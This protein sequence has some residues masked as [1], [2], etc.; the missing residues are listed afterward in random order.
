MRWPSNLLLR[1]RS[2]V[3]K[4]GL[5]RELDDEIRFHIE[6]QI[7]ENVA[8][9]MTPEAARRA[10]L[11]DFGGVDPIKEECRDMRRV[12]LAHDLVKDLRFG[13][14]MIRKNPGFT[15]VAVSILAL[16]I[17]ANTAI[18]SFIDAVMLRA[19]PV[20]DPGELVVLDWRAHTEPK[21]YMI[22][23]HGDCNGIE[24]SAMNH[25]PAGGPSSAGCSFSLPFFD[26]LRARTDLHAGIT[27]FSSAPPLLVSGLGAPAVA[28]GQLVSGAYFATLGVRAALGRTIE[29]DD[30]ARAVPVAVL[31]HAYWQRAFG[32]DPAVVGRTI[33]LNGVAVTV[34]GVAEA[35]FTR[36]TPGNVFD[37]WLPLSLRRRLEAHW[38]PRSEG[39]GA[40]W[41]SIV[42]RLRADVPAT[43]VQA[44]TSLLFRSEVTGGTAP[45]FAAADEPEVLVVPAPAGLTGA[46]VEYQ[47][48][49]FVMMVAVGIVL[50]IA[51]ANVAG[52]LLA[53]SATRRREIA[54]R[55][56]MGAGRGRI[57]R[58][59]LTESL[60]L[61]VMGGALGTVL[62]VW[63][64]EAM[65]AF[66]ARNQ[67]R[68]LGFDIAVDGRVLAFTVAV[69]LVVGVVFGLA[70][71]LRGTR[72]DLA[73]TLKDA[74]AA[75]TGARARLGSALV[76]AQ[77]ALS[78]LVLVGAGLLVRTLDRLRSV[79]PGFRTD[80]VLL[81]SIDPT[82][83]GYRAAQI[84]DL[85]R[86]LRGELAALPGV[87]SASWSGVRL[88]SGG[89]W[90]SVVR[91]V[92]SADAPAMDVDVMGVG[93]GFF[94]T[95]QIP[96]LSGRTLLPADIAEAS[97]ASAAVADTVPY[98]PP[99]GVAAAVVN[100]E[101]VRRYFPNASPLGERFQY[102]S[103]EPS[104]TWQI[105]GVV[106]DTRYSDLRRAVHPTVYLPSAGGGVS[107]EVRTVADPALLVPA[108]H[109]L[110][111][112]LAPKLPV[113]DV[114]T[115]SEEIERLLFPEKLMARLSSLFAALALVLSCIGLYALLSYEVARRAREVG[116]RMALGAQGRD[117]LRM[118]VAQGLALTA[119]GIVLGVGAAVAV[120][121]YLQTLLY[122]VEPTDPAV[123]L[124][125]SGLL[126]VVA[127]IASY[128]P[129]R[130]ATRVD[131]IVVLR[132]E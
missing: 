77:V 120:T 89:L 119:V 97:A 96:L 86:E 117:V 99:A 74:S 55:L 129:A 106:S 17:G 33:V 18:F 131:P 5:D 54:V 110:V 69:S 4:P 92:G 28:T 63:G 80:N 42:A 13:A 121:R 25:A 95:L 41:L 85:Y 15:I 75:A 101:L 51:C 35:G 11:D 45:A 53:R 23:S 1:V 78:I 84:D 104:P 10:A 76:V 66:T 26:E 3:A 50:A 68:P 67:S 123:L 34:I 81:F 103:D 52:L 59:L 57:V 30:E 72:V 65:V 49:L 16:G 2:L 91:R 44:A 60:L 40:W 6:R 71:A 126:L 114:K 128:V 21:T 73:S 102:K 61:A 12:T 38:D 64:V 37:M 88:L 100:E 27:A 122:G 90:S 58:Q 24:T 125:V 127:F 109:A 79:D 87:T 107:F 9:G 98:V 93:T 82:L 7:E 14:R 116:I 56:A 32:A 48:R 105:V 124:A 39:S 115:Q 108:I 8:A 112:R 130:R 62:A 113:V 118:V 94:E 47:G 43:Q 111:G 46:R 36:L 83:A 20:R 70:P 132:S 31:H 19:L 22:S 29:P